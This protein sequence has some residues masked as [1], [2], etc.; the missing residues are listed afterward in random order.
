MR[1]ITS[2]YK[3]NR[4]T[5]LTICLVALLLISAIFVWSGS[6]NSMQSSYPT[7][8]DASFQGH[9][10]IGDGEWLPISEGE[11]I[12]S[13]KGDVTLLGS[14]KIHNPETGAPLDRFPYS[15]P[16]TL[17]FNHINA[18]IY[19]QDGRK[20][21]FSIENKELGEDM[22]GITLNHFSLSAIGVNEDNNLLTIVIHNP[23]RF[24]NEN[25]I[26]E[27][28]ANISL[29]QGAELERIILDKGSSERNISIAVIIFSLII[30]GIAM[31][32][33]IIRIKYSKNIWLIGLVVFFA[34]LYFLF[35]SF[36]VC[37]WSRSI[38]VNTRVLCL[39]IM[40]YILSYSSL[41]VSIL[42]A[43]LKKAALSAVLFSGLSVLCCISLSVFGVVKL[44]DSLL[45]WILSETVVILILIVCMILN[46][47]SASVS[48]R[49][50]LIAGMLPLIAFPID[51]IATFFGK[52]QGGLISKH[53]FFAGFIISL[54]IIP[55]TI[56]VYINSALK[57]KQLEAEQQA[58]K[59]ELQESRISIML[60]QMQPHFIFNTLNTIYHLCELDPASAK[61]TINSFSEYLRNNIDNLGKS[62]MISFEKELS[63]VKTYLDIEKVRFDDELEIT[64][65][66]AVRSFKL[67]VLTVQP[68]VENAV[69]HGISKK[70]GGATLTISTRETDTCYE[71]LVTDTGIGFD[72]EAY[73]NDGHKHIGISNVRQRLKNLCDGDLMIDTTIGIGT[74]ATIII[75]KKEEL[76]SENNS[77]R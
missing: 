23:H 28:L 31:F 35:D 20:F 44:F 76:N 57:T 6:D 41:V 29:A 8:A 7:S 63:F 60:S 26:D 10:K 30:L 51:F 2:V 33:S 13:T 18:T 24:G 61:S 36:G 50:L 25:A 56:S 11:H 65:D 43:K 19:A 71:I 72:P 53:M 67:P 15:A 55:R 37:L 39:C 54:I 9:Y 70:N 46:I 52:W 14:F 3:F 68:I 77:G 62:E 17:Y 4:Y 16:I 1:K 75:P 58:L 27:F 38:I 21:H 5:L 74:R 64:F 40:L 34:G 32:S 66:I 59:L 42:N 49:L 12:S 69:K 45:F 22:C 48:K 47:K 73:K